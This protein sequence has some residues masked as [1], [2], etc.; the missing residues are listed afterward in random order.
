MQCC[1]EEVSVIP[2][3]P[4]SLLFHLMPVCEWRQ[5]LD[6]NSR[7]GAKEHGDDVGLNLRVRAYMDQCCFILCSLVLQTWKFCRIC[8]QTLSNCH[9]EGGVAAMALSSDTQLLVTVGVE[10]IQVSVII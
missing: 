4:G 8:V 6:C 1:I 9:P 2:T 5:A 7:P 3:F 10:E